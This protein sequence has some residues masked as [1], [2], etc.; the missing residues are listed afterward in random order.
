MIRRLLSR[1]VHTSTTKRPSNHPAVMYLGSPY[2]PVVG[3]RE[4][5]AGEHLGGLGEIEPAVGQGEA[6]GLEDSYERPSQKHHGGDV[7]VVVDPVVSRRD[8]HDAPP[9]QGGHGED[10]DRR[11]GAEPESPGEQIAA[12]QQRRP[13]RVELLLNR[14]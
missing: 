14:Q 2:A 1:G 9:R 4:V 3:R 13:D 12:Q 7:E 8:S 5:V 10:R 6:L 11:D